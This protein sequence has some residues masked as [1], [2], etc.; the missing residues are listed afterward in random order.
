MTGWPV[1]RE[2]IRGAAAVRHKLRSIWDSDGIVT[3]QPPASHHTAGHKLYL[4][5]RIIIVPEVSRRRKITTITTIHVALAK[6]L[7]LVKT[8][9]GVTS[10]AN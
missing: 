9:S 3:K 2:L 7:R 1:F 8:M 6:M 4:K 5:L 10:L